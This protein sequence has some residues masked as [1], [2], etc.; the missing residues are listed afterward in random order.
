MAKRN[1]VFLPGHYYHVYNRGANRQSIFREEDNYLLLLRRMKQYLKQYQ[2]T[3]LVYCLLPNH[4]HFLLRQET[5]KS[6][7]LLM[8]A[9]FN[10]YSKAYNRAYAHTG[11][12]FEGPFRAVPVTTDAYLLHLC[13]Y[14][15]ANPVTHSLVAHPADWPYS[16]YLEWT[17]ERPGT[18]Y[19]PSFVQ[20]HFPQPDE[21]R[22]FVLDY[23][24]TRALPE[25]L[26]NY[27]DTL[28]E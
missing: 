28:D 14:I 24:R 17:G 2:I 16:N 15:H 1:V 5:E 9:I 22:K 13:R 10:S 23:I 11:T 21:Y 18:L 6:V 19:D 8:Q 26:Q 20:T 27:L 25:D 4:Y 3:V 12:L 7:S